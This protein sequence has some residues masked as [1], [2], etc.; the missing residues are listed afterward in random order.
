[1]LPVSTLLRQLLGQLREGQM[2]S[3]NAVYIYA[4]HLCYSSGRILVASE[5]MLIL[6]VIKNPQPLPKLGKFKSI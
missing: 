3:P 5:Q 6:A 1:M 4:H 2:N